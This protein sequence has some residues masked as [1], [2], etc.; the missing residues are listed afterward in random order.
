MSPLFDAHW[1]SDMP[2]DFCRD[3]VDDRRA[4]HDVTLAQHGWPRNWLPRPLLL[5]LLALC[6]IWLVALPRVL[7][8]PA[9][10]SNSLY[11]LSLPLQDASGQK[12]KLAQWRGTPLLITMFYG[13]CA[14]A[15]PIVI[16]N[17]KRTV[18]E[19]H[20]APG[21]LH[22]L[23]V[24]LDPKRD[25][26]ASLTHLLHMHKLDPALFS[27]AVSDSDSHTRTL[28]ATL[29]IKY[30]MLDSGEINHNTRLSV[31]DAEGV[32]RADSNVS[33]IVPEPEFLQQ[34][35]KLMQ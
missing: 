27:L 11:W 9:P 5:C 4:R 24:S 12:L 34:I 21:K 20:P 14:T 15:C 19:L 23:L 26:P 29:G 28:A 8:A 33:G 22:V 10:P 17:V 25:N 7:A 6:L 35:R 2:T 30:R 1:I 13:N 18:A 31:L 3:R 16:E 32:I